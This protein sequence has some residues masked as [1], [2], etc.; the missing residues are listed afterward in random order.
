MHPQHEYSLETRQDRLAAR[1]ALQRTE[2][3]REGTV[4]TRRWTVTGI[5]VCE[6]LIHTTA[7]EPRP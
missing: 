3:T 7:A 2:V 4:E 1:G 5:E 6:V